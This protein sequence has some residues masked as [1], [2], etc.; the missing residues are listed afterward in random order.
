MDL[1]DRLGVIIIDE[2]AAVSLTIFSPQLLETHVSQMT[3]LI[4]RDKNRASV[5]MWSVANEPRSEVAAA[6]TYFRDIIAHTR[7][8]D[9][10]RPVIVILFTNYANDKAAQWADIIGLNRYH[11]WY[12]DLGHVGLLDGV[13]ERAVIK[14]SLDWINRYQRPF[15]YT[16]YGADTIPGMHLSPSFIF[17]EEFQMEYFREH[18]RAFDFLRKNSTLFI[19]EMVW[20]FADFMTKQEITRVV[21]NKKGVFTRDRQPKA[22]AHL[23]RSRYFHL[24]NEYSGYPIPEDLITAAPVYVDVLATATATGGQCKA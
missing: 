1:A 2:V 13:V 12:T 9:S 16:E 11:N 7:S 18:F 8:L 10:T 21:G 4:Q 23:L 22:S 5:V 19:G 6:E 15:I 24:A 20:N 17:T 14:E 3:E